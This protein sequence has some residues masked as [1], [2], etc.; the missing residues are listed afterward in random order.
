MDS[1]IDARDLLLFNTQGEEGKSPTL[2]QTHKSIVEQVDSSSSLYTES[3]GRVSMKDD[4]AIN[5]K[6]NATLGSNIKNV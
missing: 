5:D 6:A 3:D 4:M 1:C 2:P